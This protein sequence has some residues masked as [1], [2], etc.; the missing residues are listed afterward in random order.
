MAIDPQNTDAVAITQL[1]PLTP[2]SIATYLVGCNDDGKMGNFTAEQLADIIAPYVSAI[3]SSPFVAN[4]G[5]PLP[6]PIDKPTAITFVGVGDFDQTT[7]ANVV[8]TEE[9]NVLF[10]SSLDGVTGTWVLGV[11]VPIDLTDYVLQTDFAPIQSAVENITIDSPQLS[12]NSVFQ[13]GYYSGTTGGS[14]S[15]TNWIRTPR[16]A[17]DPDWIGEEMTIS[18]YGIVSSGAALVIIRGT[19]GVTLFIQT[20]S[21]VQDVS[22]TFTVPS[23]AVDIGFV[24]AN[25]IGIGTN[26]ADNIFVGSFMWVLGGVASPFYPK[27][28]LVDGTKI[29]NP[30]DDVFDETEII[31]TR[32][33]STSFNIYFHTG[34]DA[35]NDIWYKQ[36]WI[37]ST[38]PGDFVDTWRLNEGSIMQRTGEYAFGLVS[39]VIQTGVWE[40]AIYS[41]GSG[42]TDAIGSIHGWETMQ[43]ATMFID[44][45]E[46]DPTSSAVT[47]WKC[48]RLLFVQS[49]FFKTLDGSGNIGSSNK[50]WEITRG[51]IIITNPIE[52]LTTISLGGGGGTGNTYIGMCS[53]RRTNGATQITHT[54]IANEDWKQYDISTAG[55]SNPI[56]TDDNN[57]KRTKIVAWGDR[58]KVEMSVIRIPDYPDAGMYI[59]NTADPGYNKIYNRMGQKIVNNGDVWYNQTTYYIDVK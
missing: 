33:N 48:K 24:V 42:Y 7:G 17:V 36:R 58:V 1:D 19:A 4:T 26:P 6:N 54:A 18:G 27:G 43:E 44:G 37:R 46:I 53:L 12:D 9:L 22:F 3:G 28:L 59:Q 35:A 56:F 16:I 52:W 23:G 50:S 21:G 32:D 41:S 51:K 29:L 5:S 31:V 20:G 49:S 14:L 38:I 25:Q 13:S 2:L 11:E 55:F 15:S 8:T 45:T 39:E 30:S 10:W 47:T 40:N 57:P 34:K